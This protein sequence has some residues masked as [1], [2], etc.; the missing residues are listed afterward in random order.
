MLPTP[1]DEMRLIGATVRAHRV[2]RDLTQQKAAKGAKVSRSQLAALERG[3]NVSAKLLLKITRY[4]GLS[5]KLAPPAEDAVNVA[6]VPND[7]NLLEVVQ[8]LDLV[9]AVVE[10]IR[11][12]ATNTLLPAA[13][14]HASL[15][16]TPV[17]RDFV[18]KHLGDDA[19]LERLAHAIVGLSDEVR[20]GATPPRRAAR[21]NAQE[22]A[23]EGRSRRRG[24]RD[25]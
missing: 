12:L 3:G 17:L 22:G 21:S 11:R 15:R 7:L 18:A 16:D 10:H 19:G 6:S 5:V 1:E 4:F 14:E 24:R 13:S 25:R 23:E 2:A 9:V 20:T 8:S